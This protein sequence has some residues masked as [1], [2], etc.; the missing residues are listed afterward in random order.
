MQIVGCDL[1]PPT[2]IKY[3]P[4]MHGRSPTRTLGQT[5]ELSLPSG[6]TGQSVGLDAV[7]MF[8]CS[9]ISSRDV[10]KPHYDSHVLQE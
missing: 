3:L 7:H 5:A 6:R 4:F 9:Y 2:L 8:V 1:I 10:P